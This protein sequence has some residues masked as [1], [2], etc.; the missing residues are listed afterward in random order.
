MKNKENSKQNSEIGNLISLIPYLKP[1]KKDIFLVV[2]A[3]I[4]TTAMILFLGKAIQHLIDLGFVSGENNHLSLILGIFV[5]AVLILAIAGYFRSSLIHTV[6]EKVVTDL[7]RDVYSHIIKV[8]SEFFEITKTGD[9]ISR[10]TVDTTLL[11]NIISSSIS[12]FIRN[13]LLFI[14]GIA[15]LFLTSPKLTLVSIGIIPI[16]IAP[17]ILMG[18]KIRALS[19]QS[20]ESIA[21][22]GSHIEESVSGIK[23]IQS[24]LCEEK[25]TKNFDKYLKNS[26][27][28]ALKRIKIRSLMVA[29][30]IIFAFG[31]IATVLLVGGNEVISGRLSSGTLS[32]F[33]F[34]AILTATSLV[35]ISQITSQLQTAGG[36]TS[37]L[38][39][40]LN[41]KSPVIEIERPEK[42]NNL[43]EIKIKFED[44]DFYYPSRKDTLAVKNFNLEIQPREK[45]SIVG[46][47]GSGKSTL[48]QL[49]MRFY[50]VSSGSILINDQNIS[51]LGLKDLRNLFSYIS[52]DSF[53]FS[54]TV[55]ENIAY[56]DNNVSR[57]QVEKIIAENEALSFINDLPLKLDSFVGE[58]GIKLSGGE[59]QRIAI[60]RAIVK[61][62]P[63][64]LLDEATSAL[65]NK[66]EQ[67]IHLAIA[68][69]SRDKTVIAIAHKLSSVI[70]SDR[71]IFIK[72]GE[73]IE[74]GSHKELIKQNGLYAK[75][76]EFELSGLNVG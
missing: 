29:L 75:M 11:Y 64:L 42:L 67:I 24:Y 28:V 63:I 2:V 15:F 7:R 6:G 48:L 27:E 34:Y 9:V 38:F 17:I 73:I 43:D 16:A 46:P 13:L 49:L 65:D 39:E 59:K 22:V 44:V 72:N 68:N 36:A 33:I 30:V 31:S 3:L 25:E 4:V 70:Q 56:A 21:N 53:I 8:S 54:G 69:I 35:S 18:K 26:L 50:D 10:L 45:I 52:Q 76:Y 37:R 1:Y 66:N 55:F 20:Q 57:E 62:S 32:S 47:S 58:K 12:F 71:I 5:L 40:L 61:N 74:S 41:I 51:N 14:G 60:A 19:K 23:T